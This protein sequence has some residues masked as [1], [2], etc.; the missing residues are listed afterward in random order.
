MTAAVSVLVTMVAGCD[1][2]G[3]SEA[4]PPPPSPSPLAPFTR[5]TAA[6]EIASVTAASGLPA[7]DT[8][9][10]GRPEG[11]WQQCVAPW[12]ADAPAADAAEGFEAAVKRLRQQDWEIVSS[13]AEQDVT[14][15][16][17]VKRGWKVYARHHAPRAPGDE[18]LVAFTAVEDGC[19]LPGP[20]RG[21]YEDPA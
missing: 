2:V 5:E 12:T 4:A 17:L 13:H 8:S 3:G 14:F 10:A 6:A 21:D 11:A 16:T 19:E 20:V 1:L 9:T 15:R 18:Q 7:G